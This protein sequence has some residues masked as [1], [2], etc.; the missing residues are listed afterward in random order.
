ML[1][2]YVSYRYV[3]FRNA[4][5]T[6]VFLFLA[7]AFTRILSILRLPF[8]AYVLAITAPVLMFTIVAGM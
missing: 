2:I 1:I 3:G 8:L 4:T 7:L 6:L 5:R